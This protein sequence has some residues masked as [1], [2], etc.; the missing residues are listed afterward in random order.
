MQEVL[1]DHVSLSAASWQYLCYYLAVMNA[2]E[3][4]ELPG[5]SVTSRLIELKAAVRQQQTEG[6]WRDSS[7]H[8]SLLPL[9]SHFSHWF[10]HPPDYLYYLWTFICLFHKKN[11][12]DFQPDYPALYLSSSKV[13]LLG[14]GETSL[15]HRTGEI[16]SLFEMFCEV[17]TGSSTQ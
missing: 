10:P 1:V 9:P 12:P 5:V 15:P 13:C 4:S 6:L 14:C 2:L 17:K 7:L 3:A 11:Q 16:G 8:T